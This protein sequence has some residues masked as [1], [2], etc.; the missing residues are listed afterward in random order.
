LQK[1]FIISRDSD[2]IA[3]P[4]RREMQNAEWL[5]YNKYNKNLRKITV[6]KI[7]AEI[8]SQLLICD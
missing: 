6:K 3:V 2:A 8:K 1:E 5:S 7:G 4:K